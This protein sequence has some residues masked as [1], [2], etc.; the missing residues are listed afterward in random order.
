MK[1]RLL[2]SRYFFLFLLSTVSLVVLSTL[3]QGWA[4]ESP[5]LEELKPL[6][7]ARYPRVSWVDAPTLAQWINEGE[8]QQPILLDA[9]AP[10]EFA[11]SHLRTAIR[12]DPNH[13][14]L[15]RFLP[16]TKRVV[17]YCS[18]GYRS[19]AIATQIL[20]SGHRQVFN[21]EGGI[22]AWANQGRPLYAGGRRTERVHPFN[23]IWG[24]LLL[25]QRRGSL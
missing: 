20:E 3:P 14:R 16:S 23:A 1:V 24:R 7:S 12:V 8:E 18:V 5:S 25:E 10:A 19:G 2:P 11:M 13:P 6:I 9:R 22:F 17:V 21:L 15:D 4:Q